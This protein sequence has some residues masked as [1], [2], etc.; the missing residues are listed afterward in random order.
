MDSVRTSHPMFTLTTDTVADRIAGYTLHSSEGSEVFPTMKAVLDRIQDVPVSQC[1][2]GSL[3]DALI[4]LTWRQEQWGEGTISQT[5]TVWD[6]G[7][8]KRVTVN[9]PHGVRLDWEDVLG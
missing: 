9:N 6:N 1:C 2:W 7:R 4:D 8:V 5:V 3:A